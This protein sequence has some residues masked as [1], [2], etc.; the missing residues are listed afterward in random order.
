MNRVLR[1]MPLALVA[2]L[3]LAVAAR[4]AAG[5]DRVR[6]EIVV[7]AAGSGNPIQNAAVYVRYKNRRLLLKDKTI[8][9]T[10]KTNPEGT[11]VV[12]DVP[13]GQVLVQVIAKGWKTYGE[14]HEIESPRD[15]VEIKLER[16]K[17][18]D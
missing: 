12:P 11:A 4:L 1:W 2:V 16:P 14:F 5:E 3:F 18:Q 17:K 15:S 7:T 13:Q 6:L 8:S 10:V 9:L